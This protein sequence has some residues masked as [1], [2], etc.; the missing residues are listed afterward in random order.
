MNSVASF[1]SLKKQL[2]IT[3]NSGRVMVN[4]PYDD[5]VEVLKLVLRGVA[6]DETWYLNRYPDV[7]EAVNKGVFK[8]AW[9]HYVESGYFEDRWPVEPRIDESWYLER[10]TDVADGIRS[11]LIKTALAHFVEHGYQ[12]GR[13][14]VEY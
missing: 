2:P 12:E 4:I 14:P 5:F 7:A 11:G 3:T 8:S 1:S 13:A 9:H 6:V 10:Y